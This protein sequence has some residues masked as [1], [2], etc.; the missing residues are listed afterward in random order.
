MRRLRRGHRLGRGLHAGQLVAAEV[1]GIAR[2]QRA[3]RD[4]HPPEYT[5]SS[6][7]VIA[8][9]W[10]GKARPFRLLHPAALVAPP[11]EGLGGRPPHQT[12]TGSVMVLSQPGRN[13]FRNDDREMG[14]SRHREA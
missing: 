5:L 9:A 12:S 3:R 8:P 10:S 7:L 13:V 6:F 14:L 1:S 11:G 2:Y 4:R